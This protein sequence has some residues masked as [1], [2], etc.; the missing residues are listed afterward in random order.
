MTYKFL[1]K[2]FLTSLGSLFT[3]APIA[4]AQRPECY[5]IEESG[6]LTDLTNICNVSQQRSPQV[7]PAANN[8]NTAN[9]NN[10]TNVVNFNPVS[11]GGILDNNYILGRRGLTT[12]VF[13]RPIGLNYTPYAGGYS[14]PTPVVNR[15]IT[16]RT[17]RF[18]RYP[19]SPN[20]IIRSRVFPS[21]YPY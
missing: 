2:V 17:F 6:Q 12:G 1:L 9:N 14:Y 7:A 11:T 20:S 5:I 3:L 8:P 19:K 18:Y 16:K 13:N 21:V 4:I 15:T 10:N